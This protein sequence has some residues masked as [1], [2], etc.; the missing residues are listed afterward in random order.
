M[1]CDFGIL[2]S[3]CSFDISALEAKVEHLEG[4]LGLNKTDRTS[5]QEPLAS[6]RITGIY[7]YT[8]AKTK[9]HIDT[10]V[11][12]IKYNKRKYVDHRISNSNV[13]CP[14]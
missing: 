5:L 12:S 1:P 7:R 2:L 11:K 9:Q 10:N 4:E 6:L 14:G 13:K 3:H 8:D